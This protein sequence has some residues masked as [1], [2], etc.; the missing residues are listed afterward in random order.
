MDIYQKVIVNNTKEMWALADN[1]YPHIPN[2]SIILV[3]WGDKNGQTSFA[4]KHQE[5]LNLYLSFNDNEKLELNSSWNHANGS[6]TGFPLSFQVVSVAGGEC[7]ESIKLN[8]LTL[9]ALQHAKETL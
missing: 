4:I 1:Y 7:S 6:T 2:N 8:E 5:H 9:K 3:S